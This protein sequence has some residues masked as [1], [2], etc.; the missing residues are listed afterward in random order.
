ML[1]DGVVLQVLFPAPL[2]P[3][4]IVREP[5]GN[6]A[7]T[8]FNPT[9]P[10]GNVYVKALISIDGAVVQDMIILSF[11]S[12]CLNFSEISVLLVRNL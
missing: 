4:R 10:L 5:G 8:S 11:L 6:E 12:I 7:A 3:I 9:V 1:L 2:A